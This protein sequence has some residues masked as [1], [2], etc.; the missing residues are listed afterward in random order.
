MQIR[1][2]EKKD[3]TQVAALEAASFTM[4][5]PA[6]AFAEQLQKEHTLYMVAEKEGRVV[7]VCGYIECCGDADICNV[8][9][10]KTYQNQGVATKM[11][12][13]LMEEGYTLGVEAYT[14]E[15]R[16]GNAAAIRVYEKLGFQTEGVR[17]NF[18]ENPREDALIMWKYL[19]TQRQ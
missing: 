5:W 15:V 18:Y 6:Q 3:I 4:P 14:L 9:V 8:S 10:E 1:K 11:L 17:P 12:T 19:P 13:M 16:A 2:M 7:G